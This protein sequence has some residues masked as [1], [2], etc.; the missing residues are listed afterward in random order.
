MNKKILLVWAKASAVVRKSRLKTIRHQLKKERIDSFIIT[1]P[2]NVT[3]TTGFLGED[4]WALITPKNVYLITDSRYTEQAQKECPDSRIITRTDSMGKTIAGLLS[5]LKITKRTAADGNISVTGFNDLKKHLKIKLKPLSN[6]IEP[7]RSIKGNTEIAAIQTAAKIAAKA[8]AKTKKMIKP[9]LTENELAG[10]LNLQIRKLG[11]VNS[12]VTIVAFGPNASQPHHRPENKKLKKNDSIL[13][14]FGVK[15]KGYCCDLTR[16]L[17]IGKQNVLYKKVYDAVRQSQLAALKMIKAG[18]EISKVD[19]AAREVF[20]KYNL[21][22]YGHGTG[23]GLGLEVHE[24]P[25]VSG[26]NKERL[27]AGQV[28]TIEPAVYIPRKLGIRI[29]DDIL[30]TRNGYKI[31]TGNCP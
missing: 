7:I 23:H 2:A 4:S 8:F 19:A 25:G 30:V 3:Y 28:I 29:E 17:V 5:E 18:V 14:D 31:L 27:K 6:I 11:A 16:C 12:F 15:Y 1:T 26:K 22:V 13:I 21:P 24:A 10:I 9:G 20:R